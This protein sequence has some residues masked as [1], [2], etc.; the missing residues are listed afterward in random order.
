M[1][2]CRHLFAIDDCQY[3]STKLARGDINSSCLHMPLC[4]SCDCNAPQGTKLC[5]EQV[6]IV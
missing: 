2:M 4:V 6:Q 1:Q 5:A 3:S